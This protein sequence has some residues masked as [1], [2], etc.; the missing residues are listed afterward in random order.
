MVMED[1]THTTFSLSMTSGL[2]TGLP[3]LYQVAAFIICKYEKRTNLLFK[4]RCLSKNVLNLKLHFIGVDC[5]DYWTVGAGIFCLR[6]V[7]SCGMIMKL[8]RGA[9]EMVVRKRMRDHSD[10]MLHGR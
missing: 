9:V 6:R 8:K 2:F 7:V 10:F 5:K 4:M 3:L 1:V